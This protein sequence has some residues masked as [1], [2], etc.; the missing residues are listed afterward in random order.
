MTQRAEVSEFLS[1]RRARLTPE[2]AGII[3]G[4][5]RRVTGLRREEVA[6]LA[7]MSVD[8]YARMERGNLSGVSPEVLES[9]GRALHLDDAELAHLHDLA[10]NAAP[11]R[12]ARARPRAATPVIRP[13]LQRLLDSIS[14]PAYISNARKDFLAVNVIG[15]AVFAPILDDAANQRNNARYT[16]F[17]PAAQNFYV[18]WESGA[19]SIVASLRIEAGRNPH[20]KDLTDLIGELVTRSDV[21]R[22]RWAAHDVRFHRTGSKRIHHPDV[23]ALLFDYEGFELPADPGL[24]M[25][26]MTPSPGGPTEERLRL[27]GSL[28]AMESAQSE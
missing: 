27:L 16:F 6:M 17:N 28:S 13:A 9:L 10:R 8:Y 19:N 7:G 1:T 23:G 21:F 4:G 3:G 5:R 14:V 25:F 26:T 11:N 15:R 12:S 18:D 20:D 2:Q 24:V 22:T